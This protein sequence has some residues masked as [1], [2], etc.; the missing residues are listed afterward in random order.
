[1]EFNFTLAE[2]DQ[3]V[4]FSLFFF[5]LS[6]SICAVVQGRLLNVEINTRKQLT[7]GVVFCVVEFILPLVFH[8]FV[9]VVVATSLQ[10]SS[11][12]PRL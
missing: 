11:V 9:V 10:S 5:S 1:M 6:H 3:G 7:V 2:P 4:L 8:T 12:F